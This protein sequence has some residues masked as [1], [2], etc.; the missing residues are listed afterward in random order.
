MNERIHQ[1]LSLSKI[2]ILTSILVL[3]FLVSCGPQLKCIRILPA[4]PVAQTA[5]EAYPTIEQIYQSDDEIY[6]VSTWG[7]RAKSSDHK[8]Q[9]MISTLKGEPIHKTP[10]RYV[11]IHPNMFRWER[12][13]LEA[14]LREKLQLG[15]YTVSLYLDDKLIKSQNVDYINRSII[16]PTID[17]AVVLPFSFE[18]TSHVRRKFYLNTAANAIYGE[19]KRIVKE[20]VP[21][22]VAGDLIGGDFTPEYFNDPTRMSSVVEHFSEDILVTGTLSLAQYLGQEFSIKVYVYQSKTRYYKKFTYST[23]TMVPEYVF[24]LSELI[25]GV[26]YEKGLIEYLRT[27]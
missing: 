21:P 27:L 13:K 23:T 16:N 1:K 12:I 7:K 26:L 20:T 6:L 3:M 8:L 25:K 11:T 5:S 2:T 18:G 19:I 22:A 4:K 24:M 17:T 9:W 14:N 15:T 10:E